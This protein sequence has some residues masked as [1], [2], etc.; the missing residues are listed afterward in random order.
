MDT[1]S[2]VKNSG[3]NTAFT[4]IELLMVVGIIALLA[5]ILAPT[6]LAARNSAKNSKCL[7]HLHMIGQAG[8]LYAEDNGEQ[9]PRS[10]MTSKS[11][12]VAKWGYAILPYL[13]FAGDGNSP[14]PNSAFWYAFFNNKGPYRCP[15]D[16]RVDVT[17]YSYGMNDY[18]ELDSTDSYEGSPQ[19]WNRISQ[20]PT[21]SM[22]IFFGEVKD[23]MGDHFMPQ[24]WT[25]QADV[26]VELD[27]LR[28]GAHSNYSFVDGH[29]T[30]EKLSSVYDATTGVDMFHPAK[31]KF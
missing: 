26:A 6:L 8:M 3:R 28:H 16:A 13:G 27:Y 10:S 9:F 30:S 21:P 22:T 15:V 11:H 1:E 17:K 19:T 25:S 2:Y 23:G 12:K 7:A 20:V 5:S 24:F 4:L 14:D 29:S 31:R 18:L